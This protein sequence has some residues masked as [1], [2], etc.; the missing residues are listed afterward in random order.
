MNKLLNLIRLIIFFKLQVYIV[1]LFKVAIFNVTKVHK[2]LKYF[3]CIH[4]LNK[5]FNYFYLNLKKKRLF[6]KNYYIIAT[7][8][9]YLVYL[10]TSDCVILENKIVL[11]IY[12]YYLQGTRGPV[13]FIYI[14]Y[15][16]SLFYFHYFYVNFIYIYQGWKI[17]MIKII[18]L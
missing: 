9:Y 17:I 6:F 10:F 11:N 7:N 14:S 5:Y 15:I 3:Y 13:R 8:S 2:L 18:I 16:I 4:K 1:V 12:I